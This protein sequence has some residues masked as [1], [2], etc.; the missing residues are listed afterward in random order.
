MDLKIHAILN[1]CLNFCFFSLSLI[2]LF[3][4]YFSISSYNIG[5]YTISY[6]LTYEDIEDLSVYTHFEN[7]KNKACQATQDEDV[8]FICSNIQNIETAGILYFLLTMMSLISLFLTLMNLITAISSHKKFWLYL[9]FPH[10]I[11]ALIFFISVASYLIISKITT[12]DSE[13][14]QIDSGIKIFYI[15]AIVAV[16]TLI[17]YIFLKKF[18]NID[19]LYN[20]A[21]SAQVDLKSGDSKPSGGIFNRQG[22]KSKVGDEI[23]MEPNQRK[24]KAEASGDDSSI[25]IVRLRKDN[26]QLISELA[27]LRR[28]YEE[29]KSKDMSTEV[30]SSSFVGLIDKKEDETGKLRNLL[31]VFRKEI[32]QK[33]LR[34]DELERA[35]T[36]NKQAMESL[37]EIKDEISKNLSETEKQANESNREKNKLKS[38]LASKNDEY[39]TLYKDYNNL[40]KELVIIKESN[41]TPNELSLENLNEALL[42]QKSENSSLKDQ[43][44]KF[45]MIRDELEIRNRELS[46]AYEDAVRSKTDSSLVNYDEEKLLERIRELDS[47]IEENTT[48]NNNLRSQINELEA[49]SQEYLLLKKAYQKTIEELKSA[50]SE[51]LDLSEKIK[52]FKKD[53]DTKGRILKDF[54]TQK[55]Q[56]DAYQSQ[57]E[58]LQTQAAHN[59]SE[60]DIQRNDLNYTITQLRRET[61]QLQKR[62]KSQE[63][64]LYKELQDS[65]NQIDKLKDE[66]KFFK[67]QLEISQAEIDRMKKLQEALKQQLLQKEAKFEETS[68][69]EMK[70]SMSND[71]IIKIL[72]DQ[73][74]D[75]S[76]SLKLSQQKMKEVIDEK[77]EMRKQLNSQSLELSQISGEN[78]SLHKSLFE[79]GKFSSVYSSREEYS[80]NTSLSSSISVQELMII[81]SMAEIDAQPNKLMEMAEK[82]KREPPMT[83]SNVWKLL[84]NLIDEKCKLDKLELA[85]GRQPRDMVDFALDY[86]YL[87]FGL[88]TV[89]HKQL[90]ALMISLEELYKIS[91]PYAVAFCRMLGVFHSRPLPSHVCVFLLMIHELF[92]LSSNKSKPKTDSFAQHYEIQQYG[93]ETSI[94]D[95]MELIMKVCKND[96]EIGERIIA[97]IQKENLDRYDMIAI[98]VVG[99]MAKMGISPENMFEILDLDHGETLD[100]HEFVDSI[101]IKLN[102]WITQDEAEFLCGSIDNEGK[103]IISHEEWQD[104][105]DFEKYLEL[106][107][108]KAAMITKSQLF[109]AFIDEYEFEIIQ[110]YNKLRKKIKQTRLDQPSFKEKVLELDPNYE[111]IEISRLY[112]IARSQ[113][114]DI[115]GLVSA[116]TF[117]L[118]IIKEKIGGYGIGIFDWKRIDAVLPRASGAS[119]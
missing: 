67:N 51:I 21:Y 46:Q 101:R 32:I 57:I 63:A 62:L 33:D 14:V 17:H 30:N 118:I 94:I 103:G 9:K 69:G 28:S 45:E 95:I 78:L 52:E 74:S 13:K 19:Q 87:Q 27:Q 7:F 90:K 91:H 47:A 15:I 40:R 88:K 82:M 55:K 119:F 29:N 65:S 81:E 38:I 20:D 54:V 84:E 112:E 2:S 85:L 111:E 3:L 106:S 8:Q 80:N 99:T 109:N 70:K 76:N 24:D 49:S 36:V 56:I 39:E 66:N 86:M 34:I 37:K 60:W 42:K 53:A 72:S 117:C 48:T 64:N 18:K 110:D 12:L 115:K 22:I 116:E 59:Q 16:L 31:D 71:K 92:V 105:I 79:M 61:E 23:I 89:A 10:F 5:L 68:Q 77:E 113:D 35:A 26:D 58:A 75:L 93:G 25:E 73:N 107:D 98:K 100:Y 108:S 83:Y 44:Q 104:K 97:R 114:N 1:L 96:R 41:K 102:I 43:I 6:T 50:N 11:N 4:N